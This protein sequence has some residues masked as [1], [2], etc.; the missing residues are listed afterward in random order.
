MLGAQNLQVID[1]LKKDGTTSGNQCAPRSL[2]SGYR[3]G[4]A[5]KDG[6]KK[7]AKHGAAATGVLIMMAPKPPQGS[8]GTGLKR[9]QIL[10][11]FSTMM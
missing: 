3:I 11:Q 2:P 4:T 6:F 8:S 9:F 7:A 1:R 10:K 5:Y